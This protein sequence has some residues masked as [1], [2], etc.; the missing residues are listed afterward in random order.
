MPQ[1][2][3]Q[4]DR[5][6]IAGQARTLHE[7]L[8]GPPNEHGEAPVID[9]DDILDEW[10]SLFPDEDTFRER[11]AYDDLTESAVRDQL[12]ATQWPETEPLP[13]WVDRLDSL[14]QY[15]STYPSRDDTLLS[16]TEDVPFSH[17]L[18]GFADYALAQLDADV[19]SH[20]VAKQLAEWL[21]FRLS[22]VSVRALYVEFK[23]FVEYHDPD[24][25]AA[26]PSAVSDPGTTY[27][28]QFVE[29]MFDGGTRN[30]CL[31][32]PVLARYVVSF[33]DQ[34]VTNVTR[35]VHRLEA[36]R[37]ALESRFDVEGAVTEVTALADDAHA[38]GQVPVRVSFESGSAIYKPRPIDAG[39]ALY[40]VLERL[41]DHLDTPPFTSPAYLS[42]DSYGWMAPI[43]YA[44]PSDATAVERYYERVG[45]LLCVGYVLDLPDCQY[46][47][48]IVRGD[49]PTIIDAETLFHPYIE[50]TA[51][52]PTT[53]IAAAT[54]DSVLRTALLPWKVVDS[55]D[56]GSSPFLA[57]GLGR[58]SDT[59]EIPEIS[60]PKIE[61]VNTDV[62]AVEGKSPTV[63]RETNTPSV[64]GIDQP[65]EDSLDTI[66]SGFRRA[67]E[68]ICD[69]HE[70]GRLRDE[71][72]TPELVEGVENRMVYRPTATYSSILRLSRAR[73]PLR[74]GARL[75]VEVERLAVPFFDGRIQ[76]DQFWGLYEN[77]RQSLRRRDVPR[78]TSQPDQTTVLHD[79]EPTG[80]SVDVA[81]Y[82]RC[83][84]RLD[85]MGED[86]RMRETELLRRCLDSSI[87][88]RADHATTH[89]PSDDDLLTRAVAHGDAVLDAAFDTADGRRWMSFIGAE[90]PQLGLSPVENTLYDGRGGIGLAAAALYDQTGYDRF[91]A[92]ATECFDAVAAD[93][94]ES[95]TEF[96]GVNGTGSL[97]YTLSVAAELLDRPAYRE[98][99]AAHAREV[100]TA[101]LEADE[102]YDVVGGTAG[103]LLALLA[104]YERFGGDAILERARDC[105]EHLLDNRE[106]VD[107]KQVWIT[108][109]DKPLPG[110]AHGQSGIAYAL[111]RLAAATDD[112]RYEAAARD[113]LAYESSVY[114]PERSNYPIPTDAGGTTYLDRWCEGRAGCALARLGIGSALGDESFFD[115]ADELLS[116]TASADVNEYDHLCCG[117]L[118]RA[119]ALL[120]AT[121]K[122]G[123]EESD[124]R[125]LVGRYV[126][127]GDAGA[128]SMPGHSEHIPNPTFFNGSSGV[129]YSLLR[130][131]SRDDLP[132]VLLME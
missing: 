68:T 47:N 89:A 40:T 69:L 109:S 65:P 115:E 62:M 110:M 105:G 125:A 132:C 102:T 27:Y 104:Y 95:A 14:L 118:G 50:P 16:P 46:E 13:E 17:L 66:V 80:V 111:A 124:A 12:T 75:S 72:L 41:D 8:E 114:D 76:T 19:R 113:A 121:R 74:D 94:G 79:G 99:A 26:D 106:S 60:K 90:L 59:K 128:L 48:L 81:G 93:K 112:N 39:V 10:A 23:S 96:G 21:V 64:D 51:S 9:P 45:V 4:R 129:A 101:Q 55:D 37:S 120:E 103:V 53:T 92:L 6:A 20:P 42:R 25:A 18:V 86:D 100:T 32:Y 24:L 82:E 38:G 67:H 28:D 7:R 107:G 57:A 127:G 54:M 123:R 58:N 119:T 30:L 97:V 116:A 33:V 77:E 15:V 98:H 1:E 73:D 31:E 126:A 83:L 108:G 22:R 63:N 130:F 56:D 131:A 36:D 85:S 84:R 43:E 61:A 44:E 34:W 3:S 78:F 49:Q 71:I 11:L 29:A 5:R 2:L 117:T 70:D 52:S 35:F 122:A 88:E 91:E 87:P